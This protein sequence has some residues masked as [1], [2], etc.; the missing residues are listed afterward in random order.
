VQRKLGFIKTAVQNV[1]HGL[2]ASVNGGLNKRL[3]GSR[4]AMQNEVGDLLLKPEATRVTNAKSQPPKVSGAE[5]L[6]DASNAVV[7]PMTTTFLKANIARRNIKL[8][9]HNQNGI[10]R[11]FIEL[12]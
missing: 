11:N 10:G 8:V 1:G 9:V 2:Q 12:H 5:V 6:G 7:S 4:W 3:F